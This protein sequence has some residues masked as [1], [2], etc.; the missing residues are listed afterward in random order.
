MGLFCIHTYMK[1]SSTVIS[2]NG[3]CYKQFNCKSLNDSLCNFIPEPTT[4][5][6]MD[7]FFDTK[8]ETIGIDILDQMFGASGTN[9]ILMPKPEKDVELEKA[10]SRVLKNP[11]AAV[12]KALTVTPED[13]TKDKP[14]TGPVSAEQPT[15]ITVAPIDKKGAESILDAATQQIEVAPAIEP[16]DV[17][18]GGRPK[19]EKNALISYIANKIK[20]D[21][22][23]L[24]D[25]I[26]FDATKQTLEDVLAG[27]SEESLHTILD[28]NWAAKEKA[29][30]EQ[31]P[32]EFFESLPESLQYAAK[33]VA[34][35]AGEDQLQ[36]IYR[37]LL[38][39]E[40]VRTLDATNEDHQPIIVQN[41]LQATGWKPEQISEQIEEW[42]DSGKLAKKANE[43][44]PELDTMQKQQVEAQVR[45]QEERRAQDEQLAQ[46]YSENIH[47][48]LK[49]NTLAG[50]KLDKKWARQL[51]ANMTSTAPSPWNGQPV[52]YLGYGLHQAQ[53]V[54]PDYEAVALA[55]WILND[56]AGAIE[57]IG[58]RKANIQA[59]K[60]IKLIKQNQ[61]LGVSG[62]LE[63]GEKKQPRTINTSNVLK[64]TTA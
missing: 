48:T 5:P 15:D 58:Q 21:E 40:Q 17:S 3:I 24:P 6:T 19:T 20:T 54:K 46:F 45:I 64:R 23:G 13:V 35:G 22:Y 61:G 7:N 50:I 18:K 31:T 8:P 39:V 26:K 30:Y 57:A 42:K 52:N 44:K 2:I 37:A 4:I 60:D 32:Q 28:A 11:V 9:D 43:F 63:V 51:E 36:D 10:A 53:F 1:K 55:A 41:Y 33:A 47:N 59:E 34:A 56:K 25:T 14:T 16:E 29:L 27:E 38:R 49:D 12:E 62:Q